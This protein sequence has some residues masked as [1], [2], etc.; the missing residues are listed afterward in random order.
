LVIL[1]LGRWSGPTTVAVAIA[2]FNGLLAE[3]WN[4]RQTRLAKSFV[5]VALSFFVSIHL[6]GYAL[7]SQPLADAPEAALKVGIIQGNV[8]TRIKHDGKG[9]RL[10]L[11]NYTTGY[12]RLVQEGAEAVLTPEGTFPWLWINTP[13]QEG[14]LL[15]QAIQAWQVPAWIGTVGSEQDTKG[16]D[17]I[18]QSLFTITGT[19][20][21]FSRYDKMKLVPLGEYI[22]LQDVLGQFINR[23]SPV[24]ASLSPG[25]ATQ[26]FDTPFGRAIAAICFDS[27][28][29]EVFRHQVAAGGEFILTAANND[30]Y[31]REMMSQHH[32]QDVLRAI[33]GDRWAARATNTGYSAIIDPHGRT[34][35]ISQ[36][37]LFQTHLHTLYRRQSKTLYVRWGDWLLLLLGAS[38]AGLYGVVKNRR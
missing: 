24:E 20:E 13:P 4:Y 5:T 7:Y 19:G 17:R 18:T 34:Q 9:E 23:L 21:I 38:C 35:W 10:A 31:G 12:E 8:P 25:D 33:E 37:R 15:Y 1:H 11:Q 14:N 28:F 29:P 26:I 6:I 36:F 3:A 30:P 32:A 2:L 22:P 16:R 27:A